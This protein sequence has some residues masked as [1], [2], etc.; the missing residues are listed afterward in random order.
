MGGGVRF[1][2]V[3]DGEVCSI[4]ISLAAR[5]TLMVDSAKLSGIER[6]MEEVWGQ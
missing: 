4:S 1:D 3:A 5:G 2:I 6:V